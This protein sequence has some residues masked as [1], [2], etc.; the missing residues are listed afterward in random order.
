MCHVYQPVRIIEW[1]LLAP[2]LL[3]IMLGVMAALS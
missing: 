2:V 3:V 1:R